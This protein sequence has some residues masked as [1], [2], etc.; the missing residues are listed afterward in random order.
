MQKQLGIALFA[1]V[2][3]DRNSAVPLFQQLDT[4]IRKAVLSGHLQSGLRM[5]SSRSLAEQLGISRTSVVTAF[6]QLIAEG[7]LEG[8]VGAGTF[9]D[10]NL[11]EK[12]LE[13][14]PLPKV[15]R[16]AQVRL[17]SRL[18]RRGVLL[19]KSQSNFLPQIPTAFAPNQPA[20]DQF[21]FSVWARLSARQN[22]RPAHEL[23]NYGNA[24]GYPP[25]RRAIA[26]YLRHARGIKCEENQIIVVTGAQMAMSLSAWILLDPGDAII[27]EDPG[28]IAM[29][30]MLTSFGARM[31]YVPVD[32]K[33]M[34]ISAGIAIEPNARMALVTPSHQYP[35]G[36]TLSLS[37]RLEL[38]TWANRVGSW[39]IEDDYDS[40][41]RFSGVP[42]A[43]MQTLD[44][45]GRV[46]YI[47]TFSKVLFPS[48]RIGYLV[49]PPELVDAY[50]AAVH[51]L[52]R[53]VSTL[54]QA[55]LTEF[56]DNGHFLTHIRR[57]R[58]LYSE[59]HEALVE[60]IHKDLDGMVNVS[61]AQAGMNVIG[62]LP[63]NNNDIEVRRK[64]NEQGVLVAPM[65]VQ[66]N[67]CRPR[68]GLHLGFGCTPVEKVQPAVQKMTRVLVG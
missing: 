20:Y 14:P 48:L 59:R 50:C 60:A 61:P 6:E 43:P 55:V 65:S 28:L 42:V 2:N 40:E 68:Q 47:G 9:V 54:T 49:V 7:F 30:D 57:M 64:L 39:V 51:L 10:R 26:A 23:L 62:W 63:Q 12:I 19:T 8:R 1:F 25:L 18:S 37:R 16:A 4:Q 44:R 13:L 3:L 46:I 34:D 5:P 27:V 32:R 29:R 11:T 17:K 53:G 52:T 58:L 67:Q 36:V 41:F 56:I 35:L 66:Y 21:P 45:K 22:R 31:V 24:T 38:L 33:G 15:N